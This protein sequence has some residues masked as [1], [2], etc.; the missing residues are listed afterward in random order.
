MYLTT[1]ENNKITVQLTNNRQLIICNSPVSEGLI[2]GIHNKLTGEVKNISNWYNNH[3]VFNLASISY[4]KD[5]IKLI[6]KVVNVFQENG[7]YYTPLQTT[8][9]IKT[10]D[11]I[12]KEVKAYRNEDTIYIEDLESIC[13]IQIEAAFK[14]IYLYIFDRDSKSIQRYELPIRLFLSKEEFIKSTNSIKKYSLLIP[15]IDTNGYVFTGDNI[16]VCVERNNDSCTI[17][18][19]KYKGLERFVIYSYNYVTNKFKIKN[20][21]INIPNAVKDYLSSYNI[22]YEDYLKTSQL[23]T[24]IINSISGLK[25]YEGKYV[26]LYYEDEANDI[27]VIDLNDYFE[28]QSRVNHWGSFRV[29]T[30]I[31]GSKIY[32]IKDNNVSPIISK[33]TFRVLKSIVERMF[34]Y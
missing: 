24:V 15:E 14:W 31:E 7:I 27:R 30:D 3:D 21:N 29:Y 17:E 10:N 2:I 32:H 4:Q 18:L 12:S 6:D 34:K 20:G 33:G 28:I 1:Y 26:K 16:K 25:S 23:A 13:R 5:E 22:A 19:V 9:E 11:V 8:A